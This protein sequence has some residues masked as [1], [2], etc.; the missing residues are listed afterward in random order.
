MCVPSFISPLGF[1][2]DWIGPST[3]FSREG[4]VGICVELPTVTYTHLDFIL[5]WL[6]NSLGLKPSRSKK[7]SVGTWKLA[8]AK[9]SSWDLKAGRSKMISVTNGC[10]PH[11]PLPTAKSDL[12]HTYHQMTCTTNLCHT[13]TD[14]HQHFT[15]TKLTLSSP[16]SNSNDLSK[17]DA[18]S[19][20]IPISPGPLPSYLFISM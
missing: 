17:K 13:I 1:T 2:C 9:K 19:N 20:V 8:V 7:K 18:P 16:Y 11:T 12:T 3:E 14:N 4:F 10:H 5:N 15:M 6:E